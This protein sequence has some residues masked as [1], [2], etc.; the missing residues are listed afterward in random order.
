LLQGIALGLCATNLYGF[1][2]CRGGTN[3]AKNRSSKQSEGFKG[4]VRQKRVKILG[5]KN[6][7][8]I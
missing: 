6:A 1:Y 4:I 3:L 7:M 5:G 2:Q 8:N